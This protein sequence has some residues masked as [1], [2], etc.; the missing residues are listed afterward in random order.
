MEKLVSIIVPCFNGEKFIERFLKSIL[1]QTYKKVEL[2]FINDGS[3]DSTEEIVLSYKKKWKKRN[4]VYI[5]KP[6]K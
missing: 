6:R 4:K 1:D 2:I 3:T 5:Y